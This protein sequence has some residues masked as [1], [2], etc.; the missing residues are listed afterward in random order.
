MIAVIILWTKDVYVADKAVKL[1]WD[2]REG[3]SKKSL[4]KTNRTQ[5][6]CCIEAMGEV[7][8]NFEK[9][10]RYIRRKLS[11]QLKQKYSINHIKIKCC[12]CKKLNL[13]IAYHLS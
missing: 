9:K 2:N 7:E 13:I 10:T 4:E 11:Q 6:S 8:G 1:E 5:I 12:T 3:Q